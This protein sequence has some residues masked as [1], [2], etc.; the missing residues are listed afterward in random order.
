METPSPHTEFGMKGIGEGGAG[1]FGK[2]S[3][4]FGYFGHGFEGGYWDHDRYF[5]NRSVT[6][7]TNVNVVNVY[8]R[9]VINN[10]NDANRVS[11]NGGR[12]GVQV[13]PS[14]QELAY[15]REQHTAALPA[16]RQNEDSVI[17]EQTCGR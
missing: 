15:T 3:Y 16:Q 9:T 6:R 1:Y 17:G 12:G 2:S 13:R 7:I 4:G 14:P 8:N 5:Y 10:Y 11:F